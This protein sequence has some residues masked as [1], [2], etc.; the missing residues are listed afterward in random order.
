MVTNQVKTKYSTNYT[1]CNFRRSTRI[2]ISV[3]GKGDIQHINLNSILDH[4]K[5]KSKSKD[6]I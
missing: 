1:V 4:A 6:L 5:F 2:E 3:S